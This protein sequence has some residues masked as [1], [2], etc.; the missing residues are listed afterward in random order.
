MDV[1]RNEQTLLH[2]MFQLGNATATEIKASL[3][4]AKNLST[5]RT[6]LNS[7]VCKGYLNREISGRKYVYSPN[8]DREKLGT[9]ELERI[10]QMYFSGDGDRAIR[11]IRECIC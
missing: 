10:V 7:L 8:V 3:S 5:V 2:Q 6:Q 9:A 11:K 1:S 4:D